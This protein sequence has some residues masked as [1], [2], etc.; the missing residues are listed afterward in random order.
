MTLGT[1]LGQFLVAASITAPG[2]VSFHML[3]VE[4]RPRALAAGGGLLFSILWAGV[5]GLIV[6]ITT[7][8]AIPGPVWA[9]L[10]TGLLLVEAFLAPADRTA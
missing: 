2:L 10:L 9:A 5:V 3:R 8:T 1:L 6:T 7:D 4:Q